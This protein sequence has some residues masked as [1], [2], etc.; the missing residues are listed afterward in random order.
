MRIFAIMDT[1]R[2]ENLGTL[3]YYEKEK[4]FIVELKKDLDEWTA[5]LMFSGYV[6]KNVFTIPRQDALAWVRERLIPPGRQNIDSILANHKLMGYDEMKLLEISGGKCA[7]DALCIVPLS[8][9]PEYVEE[10]MKHNVSEAIMCDSRRILCFFR[11]DSV[12]L[13]DLK[14]HASLTADIDKIISNDALFDSGKVGT[15]GYYITFNDSIDIPADRIYSLGDSLPL[16]IDDFMAFIRK[17]IFDTADACQIL[18]CTRQ[19]LAY[20]QE[21][22]RLAAVRNDVRGNLFLKGEV[23]KNLW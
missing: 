4:T 12:K 5:P 11:D 13:L 16:S 9:M 3:L 7:Q 23:L 22:G 19:N 20:L 18:S 17:N 2:A 14:K 1:E 21:K 6:K 8:T 10:R 15:G